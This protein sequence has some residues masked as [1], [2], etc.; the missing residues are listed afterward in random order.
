M[1]IMHFW[2]LAHG[3]T[4]DALC[5]P[6]SWHMVQPGMHYAFLGLGPGTWCY[7][8][9]IMHSWALAHGATRDAL[10][11][12]RFGV[13]YMVQPEMHYASLGPGSWTL[14]YCA[15]RGASC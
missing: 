3:A 5:I 7:Q 13:W 8:G 14:A 12:P 11:I 1:G 4:R 10:C 6:D 2:A 9:W 15:A